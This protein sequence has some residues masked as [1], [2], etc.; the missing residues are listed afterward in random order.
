M[1]YFRPVEPDRRCGRGLTVELTLEQI[2][3]LRPTT[4]VTIGDRKVVYCTPNKGAHWRAKTLFTKEPATI[5][6]L[7]RLKPGMVLLDVG[8]NV[9]MYSVLA[10]KMKGATVFAFEPESQNFALLA[11]N[12]VLN[13]LE[14]TVTPYCVA[15]SDAVRLD[16]LFLSEFKWD[17]GSSCHSFGAE[18]GFDL[19][20]RRSPLAQGCAAWTIDEA[21]R[22]GAMPAPDFIK[23]DVDGFEHKV[24]EGARETLKD[25]KV[26][27]LCIEINT[28]LAEHHELIG[29]L[30]EMG[31]FY[32]ARQAELVTRKEG[33]FKG[34]AEH[35][36]DRLP[37][38]TLEV[39]Q[40]FRR[41]ALP[42][43]LSESTREAFEH[44]SKKIADC[45]VETRP[46][47]HVVID[48]IFPDAY[49]RRM[50]EMFPAESALIPLSETGRTG[51]GYKERMVC[52]FNDEHFDH[53]DPERRSFWLEFGKWMYSEEF[54]TKVTERFLPWCTNRLTEVFERKGRMRVSSD[55]LLVSDRTDYSIGPHTDAPHRLISFLFYM[56][57]DRRYQELGTSIYR[58]KD[59]EFHCPGGPHYPF[60]NFERLGTVEF[61]PNRL[62]CFVR[63]GRSFHGVEK[64]S[65]ADVDRRLLINNVRLLDVG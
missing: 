41:H 28:N 44:V 5:R 13:G 33:L 24:I 3:K 27:S 60:E 62:M 25:P 61:I 23:I 12:I 63:T 29:T 30:A 8:A 45:T 35:V 49:Y 55:A 38:A 22:S 59:P 53:L 36:F 51:T 17:G 26:R 11:K 4:T 21:V 18:V 19:R 48:Q 10:A 52:L 46:F 7:D 37:A 16:R 50:Q 39:E 32:D 58:A 65:Q 54:I 2:E 34:C 14:R 9:G 1:G 40:K 57:D 20:A 31:F 47:P 43:S 42:A 15:L 64:V 56:P 6:W